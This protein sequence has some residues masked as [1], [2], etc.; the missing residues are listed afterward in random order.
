MVPSRIRF[1]CATAGSPL[2]STLPSSC[3]VEAQSLSPPPPRPTSY[4]DHLYT[5]MHVILKLMYNYK[6]E[7]LIIHRI[8]SLETFKEKKGITELELEL[9]ASHE[10]MLICVLMKIWVSGMCF[11]SS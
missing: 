5:R 9:Q 6:E 7:T 3:L 2:V 1:Q 4:I 11:H 8:T 10:D